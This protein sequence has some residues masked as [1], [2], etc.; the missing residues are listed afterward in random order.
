MSEVLC[1]SSGGEAW[2]SLD[3]GGLDIFTLLYWSISIT[4]E[5][6]FFSEG[7]SVSA[8]LPVSFGVALILGLE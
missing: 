7:E 2:L 8:F 6:L 4:L 1:V 3:I 5:N